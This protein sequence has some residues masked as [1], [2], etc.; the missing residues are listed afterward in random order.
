MLQLIAD[1]G[2]TKTLWTLITK[3]GNIVASCQGIGLNPYH[4][5]KE[6]IEEELTQNIVPC[7][8]SWNIRALHF[9]G[10]GCR[11]EQK[12]FLREIFKDCFS[13]HT[14]EIENDLL[15]A[16]RSLCQEKEGIVCILGT[17]SNS[18]YYN[19]DEIIQNT[20]PLG[21]ILGDEGSGSCIGK[22]FLRLLL[23]SHLSKDLEQA[24]FLNTR[25]DT[26]TILE[27]V[28][29]Q[30]NAN[31][32]LAS[33][34]KPLNDLRTD[35]PEINRFLIKEFQTF[36]HY[37]L[38][39]YPQ[40]SLPLYFVGS[41]AYSFKDCLLEACRLEHHKVGRIEKD[42]MNGLFLFHQKEEL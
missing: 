22:H 18:C 25:L 30:S 37:N 26:P 9:Y 19:G 40:K 17:G 13:I 34:T 39:S 32:F 27:K 31:R 24:F 8:S 1:S 5:S 20:P 12:T 33:L 6:S 36:I 2:S 10:S 3:E 21:Y 11:N 38:H 14:I 15:G 23:K 35:F 4:N 41:I 16:A 28:Y 7:F 42:P 29:H